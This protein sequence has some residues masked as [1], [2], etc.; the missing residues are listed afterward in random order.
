MD[1]IIQIAELIG[2]AVG[3]SWL[4]HLLTIHSRA[5]RRRPGRTRRS[6]VNGPDYD[7]LTA[8]A[9]NTGARTLSHVRLGVYVT[10]D[11]EPRDYEKLKLDI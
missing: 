5:G 3:A 7:C 1:T 10:E 6:R 8:I 9:F 4:T 11:M 2:A